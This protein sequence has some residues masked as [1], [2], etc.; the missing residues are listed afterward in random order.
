MRILEIFLLACAALGIGLIPRLKIRNALLLAASIFVVY[1]FQSR[2]VGL[3]RITFWLPTMTI[4]LAA[5]S[6]AV[7]APSE[8]RTLRGNW[9]GLSIVVA[10]VLAVA[11]TRYFDLYEIISGVISIPGF[12][13]VLVTAGLAILAVLLVLWFSPLKR[14]LLP[15]LLFLFIAFFVL[16]K[17]PALNRL[18]YQGI[19]AVT[20]SQLVE[21]GMITWM[22][23]SYFAF[24]IIHTM[25]D[26]QNGLL[27]AVTLDEYVTYVIFFP[28]FVAGP[29]DRLER[30]IKDFRT[31]QPLDDEDWFFAAKRFVLGLLKKVVVAGAFSAF[32]LSPELFPRVHSTGWLWI[33]LYA[34]SFQ[35][36][37]DFSGYTDIAIGTARLAGI[38]LPE[39]FTAPYLQPNLTRFWNNWHMTLTQWFRAYFFNPLQRFFRTSKWNLPAGLLLFGLQVSTMVLIG[40]WHGVTLN[41][42]AWGVWHGVGLFIHNRWKDVPGRRISAWACNRPRRLLLEIGGILLTFQFVTV[43]WVFFLLPAEQLPAALRLLFRL[44]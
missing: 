36:Y 18:L 35:I 27:P 7:T 41:F 2:S 34:Y 11:L 43:G 16:L 21:N 1:W 39:N 23:F 13:K 19:G 9:L 38:R 40:L 31:L 42:I 12:D 20:G 4:A 6:W 24:R 5:F 3:N 14:F 33:T 28:A 29:I 44:G 25:R 32:A 26:R 17:T 22:G 15:V 10:C 8:M 30:F 37:F